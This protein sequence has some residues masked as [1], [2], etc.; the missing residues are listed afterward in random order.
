MKRTDCYLKEEQL[1]RLRKLD[2][3]V[4]EHIRRAVDLY[5]DKLDKETV[6][7]SL[8]GKEDDNNEFKS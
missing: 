8:S 7:T 2:S 4:S 1:N 3:S 6:G 5:L